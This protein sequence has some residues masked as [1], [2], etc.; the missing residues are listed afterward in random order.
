MLKPGLTFQFS[1][2]LAILSVISCLLWIGLTEKKSLA[3]RK[4]AVLDSIRDAVGRAVEMGRPLMFNIG[5]GA[6]QAGAS[7]SLVGYTVLGYVSRLCA[8]LK[9]RLIGTCMDPTILVIMQNILHESYLAEGR[10]DDYKP[11]DMLYLSGESM[12]Y[13]AACWEIMMREK[14]A[15]HFFFNPMGPQA[16]T[17]LETA[18]RVGAIQVTG[19]A[20]TFRI[21]DVVVASDYF[22][23]GE[24][25]FAAAAYLW[26][27]YQNLLVYLVGIRGS[28]ML[29]RSR[30]R[31]QAMNVSFLL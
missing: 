26:R 15:A 8:S 7:E 31:I 14:I 12:A 28:T 2:T 16:L 10:P 20:Y 11:E 29:L 25:I 13:G 6:G 22:L 4:I 5:S 19:T 9:C 30:A 24:E 23:I 18:S 21:P 17:M 1:T 3:L 27:W